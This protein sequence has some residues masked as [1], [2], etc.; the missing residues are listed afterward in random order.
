M[1]TNDPRDPRNVPSSPDRLELRGPVGGVTRIGPRA[2]ALAIA[3]IGAIVLVVIYGINKT[4]AQ[5][6]VAT[7]TT[8][9][10]TSPAPNPFANVPIVA[11]PPP[12]P[13]PTP[14]LL[15]APTPV[16]DL[17][18]QP[19]QQRVASGGDSA[20]QAQQ[21]AAAAKA[22]AEEEAAEKARE[23]RIQAAYRSP[24]LTTGEAS[25]GGAGSVGFA[26]NGGGAGQPAVQL[27][28]GARSAVGDGSGGGS[29]APAA[30][31]ANVQPTAN[32]NA[33]LSGPVGQ[34]TNARTDGSVDQTTTAL[35]ANTN[36]DDY[37]K[38]GRTAARS[39][40]QLT[41]GSVLPASLITGLDSEAPGIIV[42]Q[43]REDVYDTKTGKYMLVPRGT[44]LVGV[45]KSG[46]AYGESRVLVTWRR[47]IFPDTTNID[48]ENMSGNDVE[49]YAGLG[50]TV[51]NHT[52]RIIGAALLSSVIATAYQLTQPNQ[53]SVFGYPTAGQIAEQQTSQQVTQVTNQLV[54]KQLNIPPTVYVPKGYPFLV[55]VDR[56]IVFPS[57]YHRL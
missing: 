7:T 46:V 25:I 13:E 2:F 40:Y 39:P 26:G 11:T 6:T 8:T 48:L 34:Y 41:A 16:P 57:A 32:P 4:T 3:I 14:P 28:S 43:I 51:D 19:V 20:A 37:I 53:Q 5:K 1:S 15:E 30:P 56:D 17:Q 10:A 35:P 50:G 23:E 52:G 54:Q 18:A 29:G 42:G 33:Y 21:Y 27:A 49:G 36:A 45:Y 44:R 55:I 12:S 9:V 47:M 31:A 22:R 38:T 24:V